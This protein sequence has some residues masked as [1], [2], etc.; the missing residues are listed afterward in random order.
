MKIEDL[1]LG[2]IAA[3]VPMSTSIFLRYDLD[4]FYAGKKTLKEV[5]LDKGL[6]LEEIK[7][8]L[9]ALKNSPAGQPAT[10]EARGI[11]AY[12]K[13]RYHQDLRRRFPE[14]IALAETAEVA[15]KSNS[16]F[17]TGLSV[18]L[19]KFA[20]EMYVHMTKEEQILFP[21]IDAG[22]GYMAEIPIAF[23]EKDHLDQENNLKILRKKTSNYIP[24]KEACSIWK[25]LYKGLEL[26][27]MELTDHNNLENNTLF[28]RALNTFMP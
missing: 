9:E 15:H 5:C 20:E 18:L 26:L 22:K 24:P 10:I 14:L 11:T 13:Q 2:A 21:L 12:I 16:A 1:S 6:P 27:E 28:P 25:A 23:L 8:Q 3:G 19:K 17:P 4:F 7:E